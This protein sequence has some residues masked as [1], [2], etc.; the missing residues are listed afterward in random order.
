MK[1]WI[2]AWPK[3]SDL[4]SRVPGS[5]EYQIPAMGVGDR[6][7]VVLSQF[8]QAGMEAGKEVREVEKLGLYYVATTPA[9][10]N[11]RQLREFAVRTVQ[12]MTTGED[13]VK[14]DHMFGAGDPE[15][16]TF[17]AASAPVAGDLANRFLAVED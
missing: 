8:K 6:L 4:L 3:G 13:R 16:K 7:L 12:R 10:A 1:Q 11:A 17:W 9:L 14:Y 2:A 5:N 15:N